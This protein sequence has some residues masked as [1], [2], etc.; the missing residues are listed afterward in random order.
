MKKLILFFTI[1]IIFALTCSSVVY[2]NMAAPKNSDIGSAITFEKNSEISV[3]SEVLNITVSGSK[4]DIEAVYKMKNTTDENVS[5]QAMFLSPNID[6]G[7]VKV[8]VNGEEKLLESES[9]T[10]NYNTE[11][12][13]QEWRYAVLSEPSDFSSGDDQRIESVTFAISFAPNEEYTVNVSYL[14]NLGGYP[15][16][17]YNVKKGIIKYYLSPASMWKDFQDLTINLYLDKDMPVIKESNLYFKKIDKQQYQYISDRLPLNN[18]EI[19]IG[20]NW[21]QNVLSSF[22]NPYFIAFMPF[23]LIILI[24]IA[25]I[26]LTIRHFH[27]KKKPKI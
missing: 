5:T 18:L 26:I 21:Y 16:Y 13:T 15:D 8:T 22:K 10:L 1:S 6:S 4:A 3:L 24:C 27:K 9:F 12:E 14:Y 7:K 20:Q 17:D 25:A 2:A 19:V 11:I 23:I